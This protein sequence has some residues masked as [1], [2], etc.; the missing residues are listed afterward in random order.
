MSF[1]PR[2]KPYGTASGMP[3]T[4]WYSTVYEQ[5]TSCTLELLLGLTSFL[6][7]SGLA[8]CSGLAPFALNIASLREDQRVFQEVWLQ[9]TPWVDHVLD[10]WVWGMVEG[11]D[12]YLDS[13]IVVWDCVAMTLEKRYQKLQKIIQHDPMARYYK[14]EFYLKTERQRSSIC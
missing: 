10:C 7:H 8:E 2:L 14:R 11:R 3:F 13:L 1:D 5:S 9:G 4:L 12:H 6:W